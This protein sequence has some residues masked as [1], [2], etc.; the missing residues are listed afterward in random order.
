MKSIITLMKKEAGQGL[1]EYALILFFIAITTISSLYI[2]GERFLVLFGSAEKGM[3]T[4]L[5]AG[6][7]G[8]GRS[9]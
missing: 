1:V 7:R 5:G 9:C 6:N 3:E 4:F 2:A 8:H